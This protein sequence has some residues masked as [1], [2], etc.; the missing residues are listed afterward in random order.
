M[1]VGRLLSFWQGPFSGATLLNF[2]V[3]TQR[4]GI[5]VPCFFVQSAFLEVSL[6]GV[7][8][9]LVASLKAPYQPGYLE[10]KVAFGRWGMAILPVAGIPTTPFQDWK[11]PP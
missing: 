11:H 7:F 3:A 8:G 10:T 1:M 2:Q 4:I 5:G 6:P 9:V